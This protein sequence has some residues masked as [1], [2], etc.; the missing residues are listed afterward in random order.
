[1]KLLAWVDGGARGNPGPAG[2]GV[3][4][5]SASGEDVLRAWCF[6]GEATNNVAEYSGLIAALEEGLQHGAEEIEVRTDSELI[7]RQVTGVYRVKQPHLQKLMEE[8]RKRIARYRRFT[9]VHV[10]R[11]QNGEADR[12]ANLAMDRRDSGR[13]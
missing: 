11:E 6:L 12:L 3:F 1:M 4:L 13:E 9:I 8:V 7:Q 10:R 5:Q 2:Y